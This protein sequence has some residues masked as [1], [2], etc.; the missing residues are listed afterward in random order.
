MIG[1]VKTIVAC[2]IVAL[3]AGGTGAFA[4]ASLTGAGKVSAGVQMQGCLDP[5]K[6]TLALSD[7]RSDCASGLVPVAWQAAEAGADGSPGQVGAAG[8][9][10]ENGAAGKDG[11][12]GAAG[13][14]GAAGKDGAAGTAGK[15]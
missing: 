5:A 1:P 6:G 7:A 15:N 14:N 4:A 13:K 3:V 10:G 11:A 12:A 8:Q 2:A 9:D